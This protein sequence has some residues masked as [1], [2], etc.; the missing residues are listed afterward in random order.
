MPITS[1]IGG[2][3]YTLGRGRLFFDRFSPAQVAA[4][5]VAA[6]QG[7][8]ERFFGNVPAVSIT[9]AEEV[10]EHFASTGG[11]RIKDDSVSLQLDRTGSFTTDNIEQAN[12]ALLFLAD[13][14]GSVTQGALTAA[15]WTT[16]AYRGRFYQI[17]SGASNPTGVRKVSNILVHKGAGFTTLVAAS[18]NYE[19]DEDLGRVYIL[20]GAPDI[21]DN[22]AIRVTYDA[23][24]GSRSQVIS[25][26]T[27][28]Y[29]AL[30]WIADNP[31]GQ[32]QD[33]LIPLCKL[34]PDGDYNLVGDD[35]ATMGFTFEVLQKG[36]LSGVY[37]DGRQA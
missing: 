11:I 34:S 30:H 17:G 12:L 1:D 10:L 36:N 25:K 19:I 28:I 29:G 5:I 6:T 26:S 14:V 35:W 31:K 18:G 22:T 9:S 33:M 20:P 15:T 7:E 8:G 16:T 21:P 2:K 32:Q 3:N 23:A 27:A 37:I 13:G 24:A 4:G